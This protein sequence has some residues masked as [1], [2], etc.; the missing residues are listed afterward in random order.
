MH[1][2]N[3]NTRKP[4]ATAIVVL[5]LAGLLLSAC[6]SSSKGSSSSANAA[7]AVSNGAGTGPTGASGRA[8]RFTAL[9]ECLQKSGITLPRRTPGARPAPG[10]GG[11]L[12][13]ANGP[14]LPKGVTRAQYQAALQKCGAGAFLGSGPRVRSPAFKQAL[15]KFATCMR[16]N[17]V[18]VP[19]PN[20]SGN[21]PIF[22]TKGLSTASTQFRAAEAK[23][24]SDLQRVFR[25]GPRPGRPPGAPGAAPGATGSGGTIEG[26][27][28]PPQ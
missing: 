24:R 2:L 18:N 16:E 8:G 11:F 12:G 28:P 3:G 17:G 6:G 20:T 5:L 13:G 26:G 19:A 25:P 9:R 21:G 4:T 23:C 10:A 15:A 27:A 7:A 1:H 14:Q 22:N